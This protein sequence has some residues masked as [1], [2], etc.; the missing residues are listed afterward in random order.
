[1]NKNVK[2]ISFE[3]QVGNNKDWEPSYSK[4]LFHSISRFKT[5]FSKYNI[6]TGC[7]KFK[8]K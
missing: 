5:F 1:M 3:G 8:K 2:Y 6:C 4:T 7:I